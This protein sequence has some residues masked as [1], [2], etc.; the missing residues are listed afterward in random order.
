MP[1]VGRLEPVAGPIVGHEKRFDLPLQVG[2]VVAR[3]RQEC[4]PL[5]LDPEASASVKS[6]LT[7]IQRSVA[8]V[9]AASQRPSTTNSRDQSAES[10]RGNVS[11]KLND[12]QPLRS[13]W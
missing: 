8:D 11:T 13:P 6:C 12:S 1:D 3:A 9:I 2:I 10:W 5:G 4:R 7:R